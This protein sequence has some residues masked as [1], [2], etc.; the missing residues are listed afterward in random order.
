M[1]GRVR[2]PF[3][4]GVSTRFRNSAI[5][6]D[7][8]AEFSGGVVRPHQALGVEWR[9]RL[10]EETESRQV[11][12][13]GR[14]AKHFQ[15]GIFRHRAIEPTIFE[16]GFR[17]TEEM[18]SNGLFEYGCSSRAMFSTEILP[19]AEFPVGHQVLHDGGSVVANGKQ[20]GRTEMPWVMRRLVREMVG[21]REVESGVSQKPESSD[22]S[23]GRAECARVSDPPM[24]RCAQRRIGEKQL[25][26]E[27][28]APPENGREKNVER[29]PFHPANVNAVPFQ[30]GKHALVAEIGRHADGRLER[31]GI[32]DGPSGEDFTQ[33]HEIERQT[34]AEVPIRGKTGVGTL[35]FDQRPAGFGQ[36]LADKRRFVAAQSDFPFEEKRNLILCGV[37]GAR[38]RRKRNVRLFWRRWHWLRIVTIRDGC[39]GREGG[40]RKSSGGFRPGRGVGGSA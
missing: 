29:A 24:P 25:F 3:S 28:E 40:R 32:A 21:F 6:E 5:P 26:H 13:P 35:D 20:Q 27:P 19:R 17:D 22:I 10:F 9:E 12:I 37:H 23:E 8:L 18:V 16:I 15:K 7:A 11:V 34:V 1:D 38:N 36:A 30:D 39:V 2:I 4:R 31:R 33:N 14:A